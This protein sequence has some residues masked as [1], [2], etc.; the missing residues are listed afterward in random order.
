MMRYVVYA[1][2]PFPWE[3]QF[4]DAAPLSMVAVLL[5]TNDLP[6]ATLA[7]TLWADWLNDYGLVFDTQTRQ[8]AKVIP[9]ALLDPPGVQIS[10]NVLRAAQ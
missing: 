6:T 5:Q 8:W 10:R 1:R 4:A 7:A 3:P 9:P 2:S